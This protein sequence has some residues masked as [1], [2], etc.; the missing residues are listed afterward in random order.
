[1]ANAHVGHNC[2]LGDDVTLVNGA[3]LGGYVNVAAKAII[4]GNTGVHQFVRIGELAMVGGLAKVTQ[5]VPPFMMVDRHGECVGPNVIGLRRAGFN[6]TERDAIKLAFRMLYRSGLS[7]SEAIARIA[8][9]HPCGAVQ[10]LLS[11]LQERT[12]RGIIGVQNVIAL[13]AAA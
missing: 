2:T 10:R 9:E 6:P 8:A 11:F 13:R 4:S 1:M 7:R 5:D 3:L 12:D